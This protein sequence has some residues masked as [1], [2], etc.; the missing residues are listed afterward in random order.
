VVETKEQQ[1]TVVTQMRETGELG[2]PD[3]EELAR[4]GDER[5]EAL[6]SARRPRLFV[7]SG[8]SGVG[9]DTVIDQMRQRFPDCFFAVTATTRAPRPN[10]EDGIHYRFLTVDEFERGERE[11]AF[12]EAANVY[13]RRYGVLRG[14][15]EDA[16]LEGRDVVVKVDVQG[17]AT[18]RQRVRNS[19]SIFL[20]PESMAELLHRLEV[21]KTEDRAGLLRRFETAWHELEAAQAFDYV[22]FNRAGELQETVN[23]IHE[24][25]TVERARVHQKPVSFEF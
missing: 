12:L 15:I 5:I 24:I 7:I 13:G 2:S 16:L 11:G 1:A 23:R 25:V 3:W 17:A 18:I 22:V 14:P 20:A 8:P 6:R 21:R 4:R 10:E 9:K 19:I